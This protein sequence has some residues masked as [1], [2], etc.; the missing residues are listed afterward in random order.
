MVSPQ[1]PGPIQP[2]AQHPALS[3]CDQD[4]ARADPQEA[5][6]Q[7]AAWILFSN[8]LRDAD[9]SG[10]SFRGTASK[11]TPK[12]LSITKQG[13]PSRTQW[14]GTADGPGDEQGEV[15]GSAIHTAGVHTMGVHTENVHA[16]GVRATGAHSTS[17]LLCILLGSV[18]TVPG[19]GRGWI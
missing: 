10:D 7:S 18:G 6:C 14:R 1:A 15:L 13:A 4:P 12:V 9:M 16:A 17:T 11:F 5:G 8:W 2:Q 19:S 3:E